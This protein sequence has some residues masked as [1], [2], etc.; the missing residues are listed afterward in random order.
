MILFL[1]LLSLL[2]RLPGFWVVVEGGEAS[3]VAL[4]LGAV[5]ASARFVILLFGSAAT[6]TSGGVL[7]R[8][9]SLNRSSRPEA[10]LVG[11]RWES[12]GTEWCWLMGLVWES[13]GVVSIGAAMALALGW[14]NREVA[15]MMLMMVVERG[16]GIALLRWLV[17]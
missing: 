1:L 12:A 10:G 2:E 7:W 14:R 8:G 4:G 17:V 11:G 9:G 5:F 15:R 13:K 16:E 3:R 6:V